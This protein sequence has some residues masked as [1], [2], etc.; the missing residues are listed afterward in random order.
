MNGDESAL[1]RNIEAKV[2]GMVE[3]C[4]AIPYIR[5]DVS[6]LVEHQKE[7]NGRLTAVERDTLIARGG[8]LVLAFL[9]A[10]GIGVASIIAAI[11]W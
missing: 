8:L 9:V 3:A 1:L 6:A 11:T 7:Q 2:D 10:T 5:E 4:A